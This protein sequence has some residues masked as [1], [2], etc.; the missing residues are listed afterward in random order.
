MMLTRSQRLVSSLQDDCKNPIDEDVQ[1]ADV[2]TYDPN[3]NANLK[4]RRRFNADLLDIQ[5]ACNAG[6][7][8]GGLKLKSRSSCSARLSA[9]ELISET[10]RDRSWR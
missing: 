6:L 9:V 10:S 4:G 2:S 1:M 5:G 7:V 3:K 8:F